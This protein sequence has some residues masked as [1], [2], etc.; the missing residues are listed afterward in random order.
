MRP[1]PPVPCLAAHRA[2]AGA[3]FVPA[4]ASAK[5][6][7]QSLAVQYSTAWMPASTARSSMASP[8]KCE[9][10]HSDTRP[11]MDVLP[12]QLGEAR[13]AANRP[14]R[15]RCAACRRD[16]A[17]TRHAQCDHLWMR[18]IALADCCCSHRGG[19][20]RRPAA[21]PACTK[22]AGR[23]ENAPCPARSACPPP[24]TAIRGRAGA[25]FRP[26]GS[27]RH[28]PESSVLDIAMAGRARHRRAAL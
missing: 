20:R 12:G 19:D 3:M 11:R 18:T 21:T 28:R 13:D 10:H 26:A 27:R 5:D 25:W 9:Y 8:R 23:S 6:D 24:A 1:S 2:D 14:R 4:D 17:L 15:A 16:P 7:P 22:R